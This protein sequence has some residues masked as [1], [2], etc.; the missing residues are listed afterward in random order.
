MLKAQLP[1][2]T[3][4]ADAL[5]TWICISSIS[6]ANYKATCK[7]SYHQSQKVGSSMYWANVAVQL[8]SKCSQRLF[9]STNMQLAKVALLKLAYPHRKLWAS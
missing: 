5:K 6:H 7:V 4:K 3:T 2:M 9:T 1:S 8:L